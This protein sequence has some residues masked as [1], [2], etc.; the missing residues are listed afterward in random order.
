MLDDTL[1]LFLFLVCVC[2]FER[3]LFCLRFPNRGN[4]AGIRFLFTK[5]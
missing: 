1:D 3:S 5:F 2:V 4:V